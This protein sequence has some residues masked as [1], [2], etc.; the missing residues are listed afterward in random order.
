MQAHSAEQSKRNAAAAPRDTDLLSPIDFER[1]YG[2]PETTQAV[3]RC[4]NRYGFRQL[5][6]KVGAN[7]RYRRADVERWLESRRATALDDAAS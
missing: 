2:T 5:V 4:T 7:V 6:I 3:W 1:E